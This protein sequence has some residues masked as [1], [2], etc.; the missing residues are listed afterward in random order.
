MRV[1]LAV[2]ACVLGACSATA[3]MASGASPTTQATASEAAACKQNGYDGTLVGAFTLR[4]ADLAQ[5][6]ETRGGVNGPHPLR[7]SFRDY[8]ADAPI[9]LCFFDGFIPATQPRPIP[10]A[11]MLPPYDRYVLTVDPLGNAS[12]AVAGYRNRIV[13]EPHLP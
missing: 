4:A 8:P 13:V 9:V 12:L 6:D 7:S 5:Q 11:T 1:G 2:L 10:P 3:T